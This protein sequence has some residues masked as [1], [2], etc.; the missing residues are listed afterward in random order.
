LKSAIND[1]FTV[2]AGD[3]KAPVRR[4]KIKVVVFIDELD[5]CPLNRIVD[6]LDAIKLF[7]D[8]DIFIVL[9]AVDTRVATEAIRLYHKDVTNP[10]LAREY[11]E[12]IV[13][14]PHG[15]DA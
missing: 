1:Y 6:I 12:K 9:M 4:G 7:L 13:Q 8:E 3:V 10:E 14:I 2:E 15:S 5:R 11:L